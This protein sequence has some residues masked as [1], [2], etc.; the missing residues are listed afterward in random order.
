[1]NEQYSRTVT[2]VALH[3]SNDSP[4][5]GDS[6]TEISLED[7]GGGIFL[8]IS[9]VEEECTLRF[10]IEEIPHLINAIDYMVAQAKV[11]EANAEVV[12]KVVETPPTISWMEMLNRE[13]QKKS[14]PSSSYEGFLKGEN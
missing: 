10:N 3:L 1:M 8:S 13:L 12:A 9:Q 5:N 6:T 14:E 2:R 11:V 7:E 4:L